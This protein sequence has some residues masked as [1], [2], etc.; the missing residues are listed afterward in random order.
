MGVAPSCSPCDDSGDTPSVSADA[1]DVAGLTFC[2]SWDIPTPRK[3]TSHPEFVHQSIVYMFTSLGSITA[4]HCFYRNR[5][6]L[7][8]SGCS[9]CKHSTSIVLDLFCI[10]LFKCIYHCTSADISIVPTYDV[11]I[12]RSSGLAA[13]LALSP[14]SAAVA[15]AACTDG[16][17]ACAAEDRSGSAGTACG[18]LRAGRPPSG[19]QIQRCGSSKTNSYMPTIY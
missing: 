3:N 11:V 17:A 13:T 10:S 9:I 19:A 1:A 2:G 14:T 18:A 5:I 15:D 16:S 8:T 6:H 7:Y 4:E 12:S